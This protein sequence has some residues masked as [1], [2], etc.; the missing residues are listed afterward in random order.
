MSSTY[1]NCI[2][3][4]QDLTMLQS[5][6]EG[7]GYDRHIM[8]D[9]TILYNCAAR[10]LIQLF[11]DGVTDPSDLSK[12]MRFLFGVHKHDRVK[13][14]KPLPRYAIQGLPPLYR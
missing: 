11:Q 1:D 4:S 5:V 2:I 13:A 10:K 12:E 14:W 8:D 7:L 6:L 3:S 9:E